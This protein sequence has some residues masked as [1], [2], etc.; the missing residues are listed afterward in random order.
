MRRPPGRPEERRQATSFVSLVE[1]ASLR[2]A[3]RGQAQ[4]G[5]ATPVKAATSCRAG[6]ET[7][8]NE[9]GLDHFLKRVARLGKARGERL[10]PDRPATVKFG[11]HGQVTPIH[12]VET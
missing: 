12:R 9:K 1:Q 7:Q 3:R 11:D 2:T 5:P 6:N 4:M 8:L 10:D